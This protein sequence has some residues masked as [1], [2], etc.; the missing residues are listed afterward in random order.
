[1]RPSFYVSGI[2]LLEINCCTEN[3]QGLKHLYIKICIGA[4]VDVSA[5]MGVASNSDG[6]SCSSPS[7]N[8]LGGELGASYGLGAEVSVSVDMG[9]SG[10]SVVSSLR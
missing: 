6:K 8:L 7:N 2:G 5:G 10:A 4:T 1:V 3:G 9:G